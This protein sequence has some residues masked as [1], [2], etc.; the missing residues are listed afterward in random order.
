MDGVHDLG[1]MQGFGRIEREPD[2]PAF[3][4]DWERR[5][6]G[7]N[8]AAL[9]RNVDQFRHAIERMDPVTY[10]RATYYEKWLHAIEQGAVSTGVVTEVELAER[11][12]RI[13]SA[14][15]DAIPRREDPATAAGLVAAIRVPAVAPD[16]GCGRFRPGDRVRVRRAAPEGHTRCPAYVR[17][18]V[19]TVERCLGEHP[20]PDAGAVG[21][22]RPE[23]LY[24]VAVA[25]DELWAGADHTVLLDLWENYLDAED[26]DGR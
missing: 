24:T 25:A 10:L 8:F 6:F 20:L 7:L 1:G 14:G 3:H 21:E 5:V 22:R 23:T 11:E 19:G 12:Q 26:A 15:R 2:E 9:P 16:P 18:A 4:H 17:G 13:A